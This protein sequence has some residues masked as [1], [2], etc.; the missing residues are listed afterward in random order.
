MKQTNI[1]L[2]TSWRLVG[3]LAALVLTL[4]VIGAQAD[5][6]LL[7]F[8]QNTRTTVNGP[9][10]DD[11]DRFWNNVNET[12]GCSD[13]G[14]ILDVVT[15]NN[16]P[17]Y[18][19]FVMVR[20]FNGP[21]SVGTSSFSAYPVDATADNLYGNTGTFNT[22]A[23]VFPSFKLTQLDLGTK[24]QFTFY[25]SRTSLGATENRE[26]LYVVQGATI[27]TNVLNPANNI[28]NVAVSSQITPDAAGEISISIYP[29]P[30]NNNSVKFTHLSVMQ[31]DTTVEAVTPLEFTLEP[32]SQEVAATRDVTFFAAVSGSGPFVARWYQDGNLMTEQQSYYTNFS[33]TIPY[34][35]VELDN[36]RFSVS[37]SNSLYG[38]VSSNA[39]LKVFVDQT[40][41]GVVSVFSPSGI[42]ALLE[43]SEEMDTNTTAIP[44]Y[45]TINGQEA[46]SAVPS[47]DKKK[48]TLTFPKVTGNYTV[49]V[50]GVNDWYGNPIASGVTISGTAGPIPGENYLVD[51]GGTTIQT[52]NEDCFAPGNDPTNYWNNLTRTL[53]MVNDSVLP[54]RTSHR[55][56]FG[57][58]LV[59]VSRFNDW[60]SSG[61]SVSSLFPANATRDNLYGNIELWQSL[62]EVL[63]VMKLTGLDPA[64]FYK[65]TFHASRGG[66]ADNREVAYTVGGA[67]TNSAILDAA[68]NIDQVAVVEGIQPSTTGEVI[69][70]MA[71]GPGNNNAYHFL[72]LSAFKVEKGAPPAPRF[73]APVISNGKIELNWT[74]QGKLEWSPTLNG[75]WAPV[76]PE[77]ASGYMEDISTSGNRFYRLEQ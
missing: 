62:T 15:T 63:P 42:S 46:L 54:L 37:V 68:N 52:V 13:T 16:T 61:T 12:V 58:N 25:A 18:F 26:T 70:S 45:Y 41:P 6:I 40:A 55:N 10:P 29:G 64:M 65:F 60:N 36:A 31:V 38:V 20:R 7:D 53:G 35:G 67:N 21:N 8:G 77:P 71:P 2:K 19:D 49:A 59:V 43:F 51:I 4:A 23:N 30:N 44:A 1:L 11:P 75:P 74:G 22:R 28:E 73:L 48:V 33:Y 76:L 47:A 50:G 39:V 14:R 56:D 66:A 34:A 72:H 69:I 57:V 5:T 9:A 3:G 24:Y 27:E 32:A 17:T